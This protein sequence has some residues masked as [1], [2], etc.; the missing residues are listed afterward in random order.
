MQIFICAVHPQKVEFMFQILEVAL[1]Q[2]LS[3]QHEKQLEIPFSLLRK[4]TKSVHESFNGQG[5]RWKII[6]KKNKMFWR[7]RRKKIPG[8]KKTFCISRSNANEFPIKH[9]RLWHLMLTMSLWKLSFP[10]DFLGK[11]CF[12]IPLHPKSLAFLNELGKKIGKSK[13]ERKI[14]TKIKV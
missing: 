1:L 7:K 14:S 13:F 2:L 8:E 10:S 11:M 9:F 6:Q 12:P 5:M 4:R 3:L